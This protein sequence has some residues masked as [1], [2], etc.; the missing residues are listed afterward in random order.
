MIIVET[1]L[2][3][4]RC[5]LNYGVDNRHQKGPVQRHYSRQ[6]GWVVVKNKDFCPN[7]AKLLP[8]S[9]I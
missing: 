7:C 5:G 9:N 2:K 6:E 1:F 3:C 8:I 4:D